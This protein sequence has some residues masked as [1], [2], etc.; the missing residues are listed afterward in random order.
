[1]NKQERE[2]ALSIITKWYRC[3]GINYV[4]SDISTGITEAYGRSSGAD[5]TAAGKLQTQRSHVENS[6]AISGSF[7]TL[8]DLR[9]FIMKTDVCGLKST[10]RNTV[11]ADGDMEAN[12]MIIGEAPGEEEDIQGKPFVGQ[13]GKLLNNM[14]KAVG[15]NRE[16]T[17]IT[18]IL[19]WRPPANRT[20]STD[21]I[22]KCLPYVLKHIEF[23]APKALLLLGGV[24]IKA[25]T[26]SSGSISSMRSKSL[27]H[28]GIDVIT[29]FHPAYLLRSPSQK[30][31]SFL[32]MLK[33][34]KLL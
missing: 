28:N 29:T 16:N 8:A 27:K 30:A 26:N 10:S 15:F 13:S 24:A 14:L 34:R 3:F 9:S 11:F 12:I 19:F 7:E 22:A 6:G 25:I 18:N 31:S 4:F 2:K 17:Y 23:I 32:D 1:M 20:P 5:S 33:L 21:E